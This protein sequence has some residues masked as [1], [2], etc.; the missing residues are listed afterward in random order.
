[1]TLDDLDWAKADLEHAKTLYENAVQNSE[2]MTVSETWQSQ[3][4][5]WH[6]RAAQALI[7]AGDDIV[8]G[9]W[10]ATLTASGSGSFWRFAWAGDGWFAAEHTFGG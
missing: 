10:S 5:T 9:L 4:H 3:A 7:P 2:H 8:T 1:M 6:P